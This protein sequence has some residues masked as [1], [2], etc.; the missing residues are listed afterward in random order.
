MSKKGKKSSAGQSQSRKPAPVHTV[1]NTPLKKIHEGPEGSSSRTP[2]AAAET[3]AT[4]QQQQQQQRAEEIPPG[5]GSPSVPKSGSATDADSWKASNSSSSSVPKSGSLSATDADSWK[6]P[7]SSSSSVP[8]SSSPS[9]TDSD[10]WK[11]ADVMT[12]MRI[13]EEFG[14]EDDSEDEYADEEVGGLTYLRKSAL[15]PSSRAVSPPIFYGRSQEDSGDYGYGSSGGEASPPSTDADTLVTPSTAVTVPVPTPSSQ[16]SVT[17]MQTT[18]QRLSPSEAECLGAVP[19]P[20]PPELDWEGPW[21]T[22]DAHGVFIPR[23]AS[24]QLGSTALAA[25]QVRGVERSSDERGDGPAGSLTHCR[26]REREG[27]FFGQ[28]PLS[29]LFLDSGADPPSCTDHAATGY[30]NNIFDEKIEIAEAAHKSATARSAARERQHV[31]HI[32][33]MQQSIQTANDLA[34]EKTPWATI[35]PPD[36]TRYSGNSGDVP[37]QG[38]GSNPPHAGGSGSSGGAGGS[39]GGGFPNHIDF[40]HLTN[41]QK[42]ILDHRKAALDEISARANAFQ[43]LRFVRV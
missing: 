4:A 39:G 5:A 20:T 41:Q 32:V 14:S 33:A 25:V 43:P 42:I 24:G 6:A 31:Q 17:P 36:L 7:N 38:G 12:L 37:P 30:C 23:H 35:V 19:T 2:P 10:S 3:T 28:D 8:K 34:A 1:R 11:E 40:E 29:C 15:P 26:C 13:V 18:G 16:T 27:L 21:T 22:A 9:T